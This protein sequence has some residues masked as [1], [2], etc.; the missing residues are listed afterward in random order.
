MCFQNALLLSYSVHRAIAIEMVLQTPWEWCTF[1]ELNKC[2]IY[3]VYSLLYKLKDVVFSV[4]K[5]NIII[6]YYYITRY[7]LKD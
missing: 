7:E 4:I 3:N 5:Y 6:P 2:L 1:L